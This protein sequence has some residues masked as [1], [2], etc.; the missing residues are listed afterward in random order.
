MAARRRVHP[1]ARQPGRDP[2]RARYPDLR[3]GDPQHARPGRGAGRPADVAPADLRRSEPRCRQASIRRGTRARGGRGRG[4]WVDDGGPPES[5]PRPLGRHAIA[6]LRRVRGVDAPHF[7]CRQRR[8][9]VA[10]DSRTRQ[11]AM[12]TAGYDVVVVGGGV[13]GC[14]IAW[15]LARA[16][17][18]VAV[19]ER[20]Q[21]AS[22]ASG[23]SAGGVRQQGRDLREFPLAFRAIDRWRNLE[24]E[25]N[26]NLD[27]RRNG[28][29]TTCEHEAD[30]AELAKYVLIQ[31]SAGLDLA[32]VEGDDLRQLIPG[33]APTVIAAAY[34]PEDGHANPAKTTQAFADAARRF[35]ATIRTDP[36]RHGRAGSRRLER[37]A[38][39]RDRRRPAPHA[40]RLPGDDHL[41]GRAASDP[42]T[43]FDAAAD[44]P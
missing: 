14:S 27:Y 33:I 9:Q 28:H 18:R 23:A 30:L 24:E 11:L 10:P 4:G 2:L 39:D 32:L 7:G 35:G 12:S 21:I 26:A 3:K 41:P 15:H 1:L 44:Q 16:G 8:R 5:G 36:G 43:G 13:E 34:S 37:R 17:V 38:G 20:W 6:Q 29:A 19:L 42:G 25:L 40:G 31:R 22:A